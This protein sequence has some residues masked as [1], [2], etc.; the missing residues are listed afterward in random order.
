M[1]LA[2]V[3]KF[4]RESII[5]ALFVLILGLSVLV[6]SRGNTI[7]LMQ[8][9]HELQLTTE[10]ATYAVNA[11][12]LERESYDQTIQAINDA[13]VREHAIT[14][15][16]ANTGAINERLSQ[17]IDRLTATAAIDADFRVEY[18]ATSGQL[19]KECSGSI[20]ALAKRADGHVSDIQLLQQSQRK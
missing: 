19:L 18:A 14:V 10:R 17:T 15:D 20:T 3:I 9:E 4:W 6:A 2:L 11:R 13:K 5:G 7:A 1:Y 12:K 16:A 8:A